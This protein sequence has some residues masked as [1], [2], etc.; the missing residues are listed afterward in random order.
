MDLYQLGYNNFLE[1]KP[2][3]DVVPTAAKSNFTAAVAPASIASGESIAN[4]S[5]VNGY[6]QSGNF[7]TGVTGWIINADGSVEFGSGN[8]R[9]SITGATGTF[10]GAISAATGTIGGFTITPSELYGG[11]IKTN[12]S[13]GAVGSDGVIMDSAGLRGY[14]NT[15]G[16][17][18]N[19]PTNGSQPTF[20]NGVILVSNMYS[21]N[22]AGG[23][24]VGAVITGGTIRTAASGRRIE[25]DSSGMKA[26]A[27][28]L[29]VTYGDSTKKYGDATRLYGSGVLAYFN[30]SDVAIPFYVN[31]EQTVA[32]IHLYN[33]SANPSGKAEIG[34]IACVN[35]KQVICTAGGTPGT[36]TVTGTQV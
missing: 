20:S 14:S 4:T 36:W 10:S 16:E 29:G 3:F 15:L 25:I 23:T 8:F 18:F 2:L 5:L 21:T 26:I 11:I 28:V 19:I 22:I 1:K 34:D 27:G 30:N 32:D 13:A 35:N 33:R 7:V 6:L 17:V 24:L 9:G 12:V 31:Q